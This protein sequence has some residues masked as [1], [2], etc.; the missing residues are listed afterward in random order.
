M[1]P[2]NL[3]LVI[4]TRVSITTITIVIVVEIIVMEITVNY[5]IYCLNYDEGV[6]VSL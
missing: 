1:R 6:M 5:L 2:L 4:A 3:V